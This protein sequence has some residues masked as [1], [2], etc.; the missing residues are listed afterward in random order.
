MPDPLY[1]KSGDTWPPLEATLTDLNGVI[2][3][4]AADSVR[5]VMKS[6][7]TVV[8]GACD[9]VDAVAGVVEYVWAP[10]DT[11]IA[12]D[13]ESEFEIT[14]NVGEIQTVPNS[15]A[16]NPHVIIEADLD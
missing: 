9:V 6:G 15:K 12:G 4:S 3:L 7:T 1:I 14:W 16:N 11:V 10:G 2:D 13:Y 8:T 5:L